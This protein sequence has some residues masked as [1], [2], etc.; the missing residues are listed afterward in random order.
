MALIFEWTDMAHETAATLKINN[1]AVDVKDSPFSQTKELLG[2]F[3]F[4]EASDLDHTISPISK[5]PGVQ[6]GSFE[7][8]A[9]DEQINQLIQARSQQAAE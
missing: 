5:Y 6:I 2:G 7:I 8:R 4:Q 3:L 9:A 1:G